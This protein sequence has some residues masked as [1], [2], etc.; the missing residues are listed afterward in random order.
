MRLGNAHFWEL[1]VPDD[2]WISQYHEAS[3][4]SQAIFPCSLQGT[5]DRATTQAGA[6]LGPPS[7]GHLE[8]ENATTAEISMTKLPAYLNDGMSCGGLVSTSIIFYSNTSIAQHV[9][10]HCRVQILA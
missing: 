5:K 1:A 9:A 8:L 4:C 3:R 6:C 2:A 10:G 7:G